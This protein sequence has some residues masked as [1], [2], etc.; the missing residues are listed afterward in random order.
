MDNLITISDFKG[1]ITIPD[2]ASAIVIAKINK[3]IEENQ[4]AFLIDAFGYPF[5]KLI[6]ETYNVTAPAVPPTEWTDF[7]N[8]CE[9][10]ID[11]TSYKYNGLKEILAHYVF[12]VYV[13]E[14][15]VSVG[16]TS[17]TIP[18]QENSQRVDNSQFLTVVWN[19]FCAK[20]HDKFP[21]PYDYL[22]EKGIDFKS[23]QYEKQ[24]W[25]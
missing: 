10:T 9:I 14:N 23:H 3:C 5:Y 7:V 12:C 15:F 16:K 1:L 18:V 6:E 21:T 8:G 13:S 22:T 11:G 24:S 25:L 20:F 2:Q 4:E 17:V 19:R